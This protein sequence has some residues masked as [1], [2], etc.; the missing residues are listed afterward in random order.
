MRPYCRV[1]DHPS[2]L[3]YSVPLRESTTGIHSTLDGHMSVSSLGVITNTAAMNNLVYVFV[4]WRTYVCISGEQILLSG[5]A[6]SY[7]TYTFSL[8]INCIFQRG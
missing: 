1:I 6:R 5:L 8:S 4:D 3:E 2:S 7:G